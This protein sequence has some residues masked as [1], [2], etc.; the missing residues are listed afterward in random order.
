MQHKPTCYYC[1]NYQRM[2][3]IRIIHPQSGQDPS[4]ETLVMPTPVYSF[5][6]LNTWLT[7]PLS[8]AEASLFCI[9]STK[10]NCRE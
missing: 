3:F 7:R 2:A 5:S 4:S 10:L 6:I 1:H 9:E 8:V